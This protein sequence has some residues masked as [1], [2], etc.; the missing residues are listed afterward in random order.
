VD[1]QGGY[2]LQ[3]LEEN[4]I[5]PAGED[6]GY[7]QTFGSGYRNILGV[8]RGRDPKLQQEFIVIGAHYDHVGYGTQRNSFGPTGSIHNGADDNASG[9]AG[10]LE[11]L[12]A[13]TMLPEAPR[14]SI[15]F[16]FWDGEE[17]GLLGSKHW[18]S[19]PTVPLKQVVMAFNADMIGRLKNNRLEVYGA[20]SAAGLRK[21]VS[22]NNTDFGLQLD[23]MWH[24]NADSDHYSSSSRTFRS[25]MLHTVCTTI[26][27]GPVTTRNSS[28]RG[29]RR[30][31]SSCSVW[32][33]IWPRRTKPRRFVPRAVRI[34]ATRAEFERSGGR[35]AASRRFLSSS[36]NGEG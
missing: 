12:Q 16:A 2:L 29:C 4:H 5:Q 23:F 9:T 30:C 1:A 33:M 36:S 6:G 27:T 10:V 34:L 28:R 35:S 8:I 20:R 7:F 22:R 31:R 25:L 15:M 19:F 21:L 11:V 26:I 18:T 17:K 14:R 24:V 13:F 3:L 32:P